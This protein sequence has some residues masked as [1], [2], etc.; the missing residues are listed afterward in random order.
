MVTPA[1]SIPAKTEAYLQGQSVFYV[2]FN[3]VDFYV[4]DEEQENLYFIILR[5]LLPDI[6]LERIFALGGKSI[7]I[8]HAKNNQSKRK[9]VYILDKDFDDLLK[10]QTVLPNLFYLDAFCIENYLIEEEAAVQYVISEK[11]KLKQKEIRQKLEFGSFTQTC[12]KELRELHLLFFLAQKFANSQVATTGSKISNYCQTTAN[13]LIDRAKVGAYA[14]QVR[15]LLHNK[16]INLNKVRA[17]HIGE[18]E[19]DKTANLRGTNISGKFVLTLLSRKIAKTFHALTPPLESVTYRF[20]DKCVFS[21]LRGL[22]R[23]IEAIL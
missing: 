17:N 12:F 1:E 21:S 5:K 9:S 16:G 4:E 13:F 15:Q 2:Q 23:R 22:K 10:I 14:E 20:A 8:N 7:V 3:D 6:Q 11:P 19:L 18:F